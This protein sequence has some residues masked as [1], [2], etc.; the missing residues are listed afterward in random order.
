MLHLH[1]FEL[2]YLMDWISRPQRKPI[3]MR[4][5]RQVGKSTLVRLFA[6][7]KGLNLLEIDFEQSPDSATLFE[8]KDPQVI[9]SLLG[10][11]FNQKINPDK[12]LLFLD[13]IQ[14]TPQV[15]AC[16]RYFFEKMP[17]LAVICAGSLLD[18]TL[19]NP[20]FSMPVGRVEYLYLGPMSFQAFLLG[21]GKNQL[22]S[23][24]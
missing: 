13:E 14:S 3:V 10:V 15:L 19:S 24:L 17:R 5:A 18:L 11:K 12:T 9:L 4:G 21:L 8:S 23:F 22:I 2:E 6:K 16:L 20:N 1:R 7:Q